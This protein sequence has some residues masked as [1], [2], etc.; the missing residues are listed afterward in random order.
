MVDFD[1]EQN[2][3]KTNSSSL[4]ITPT[5]R[6]RNDV[7]NRAN[8]QQIRTKPQDRTNRVQIRDQSNRTKF[9]PIQ[10]TWDYK[11]PCKYCGFVYLKSTPKK[12]R[13]LCCMNG[14]AFNSSFPLLRPLP[15]ILKRLCEQ[16]TDHMSPFSAYYNNILSIAQTTV[17]NGNTDKYEQING[18]HAVKLNGRVIHTIPRNTKK[19]SRGLSYFTYDCSE[20]RMEDHVDSINAN[21]KPQH[22]ISF[23]FLIDIFNEL[24][25]YNKYVIQVN[26]Y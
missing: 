5:K 24:K 9:M 6:R 10:Q 14:N 16:Y 20:V 3:D 21:K 25:L 8:R 1:F 4:L 7:R 26:F 22:K 17:K 13:H 2:N 19:D 15:P 12:S 23:L 18:P 11:N